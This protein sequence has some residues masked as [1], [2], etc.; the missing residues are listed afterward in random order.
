V[1]HLVAICL[2]FVSGALTGSAY[3]RE[4]NLADLKH[5]QWQKRL[6]LIFAPSED[7]PAYRFLADEL[8]RQQGGVHDRDV[9]VFSLLEK[10]QSRLGDG[11]LDQ[12]TG[13]ALRKRF[14]VKQGTFTVILI[15]KDGGE[16]LRREEGANLGEIFG[17]IDTMPM[18]RRE[19]RR[20][21]DR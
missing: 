1:K 2:V 16:K 9:L 8:R 17:L 5:Y 10:G 4:S 6:L 19:M 15:G 14:S 11:R 3:S 21:T 20:K 13:E 18:R 12:A 7:Y